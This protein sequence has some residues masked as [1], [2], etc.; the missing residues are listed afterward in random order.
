M[1]YDESTVERL[2]SANNFCGMPMWL[3]YQNYLFSTVEE[4]SNVIP[5]SA[6]LR[7][8]VYLGARSGLFGLPIYRTVEG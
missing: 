2:C 5:I 8:L 1:N 7:S 4:K 6:A 3:K